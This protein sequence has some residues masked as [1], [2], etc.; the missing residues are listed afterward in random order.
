[1]PLSFQLGPIST[2]RKDD[3]MADT[4]AQEDLDSYL[5]EN[6][7]TG[8]C[9]NPKLY[10]LNTSKKPL[11][12]QQ[13]LDILKKKQDAIKFDESCAPYH[14]VDM[15]S[16]AYANTG[17]KEATAATNAG[18][19]YVSLYNKLPNNPDQIAKTLLHEITHSLGNLDNSKHSQTGY[20]SASTA[21][22]RSTFDYGWPE[23]NKEAK[24]LLKHL[25][26]WPVKM[27][28]K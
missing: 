15:G 19:P 21:E 14:I 17:N 27:A 5:K 26:Q 13:A 10:S 23:I 20:F 4:T 18:A 2:I 24:G 16:D 28:S 6:L 3:D 8:N 25:G 1:V 9:I 12:V 22:P 7:P 11:L